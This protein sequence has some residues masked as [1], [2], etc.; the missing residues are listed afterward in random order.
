[1]AKKI[2]PGTYEPV[3]H[4]A[5]VWSS[6][7]GKETMPRSSVGVGNSSLNSIHVIV[8][9]HRGKFPSMLKFIYNQLSE[10]Y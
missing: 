5:R 10:V 3:N 2:R 6:I 9:R 7:S 1:M 8:L 4:V